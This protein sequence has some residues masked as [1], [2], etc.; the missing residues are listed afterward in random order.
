[1]TAIIQRGL[2]MIRKCFTVNPN[3]TKEEIASYEEM[4]SSGVYQGVEIFY[5]YRKKIEDIKTYQEAIMSYLKYNPEM[6]C[7]LPYGVDGNLAT[8]QNL[9]QALMW[10]KDAIK[11]ASLFGVKKA[12]LHPGFCDGTLD[13]SDAIRLCAQNIKALCQYAK[14]FNIIIMLENLIGEQELMR[15]PEEY[16][17][18]KALV[19]ED[20]LK[21]IFDVAHFHASKFCQQTQ[22]ILDFVEQV[23]DDLYHLHISDNDGTRDMHAAIGVG[24]ID[25]KAYFKKLKEVGYEGLYSSEVLFNSPADL[26]STAQSMDQQL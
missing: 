9:E 18:L 6:V 22:D 2:E 11:F 24:I 4:L 3:R 8:Y 12:T 5:P 21:M 15:T 19:G 14:G 26:L 16:F 25:F 7:H 10:I 17:E 13:R 23:K 20:N 1:M